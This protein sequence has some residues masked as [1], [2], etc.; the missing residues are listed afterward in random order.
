LSFDALELI[1]KAK[2]EDVS[3]L[4]QINIPARRFGNRFDLMATTY[5]VLRIRAVA[6][7]DLR[8]IVL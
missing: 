7:V 6:S 5:D 3:A 2:S 1:A 8:C 4:R